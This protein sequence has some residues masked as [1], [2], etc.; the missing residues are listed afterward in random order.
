MKLAVAPLVF[1]NSL[2]NLRCDLARRS[3]F[4][5]NRFAEAGIAMGLRTFDIA[6][7]HPI[8]IRT[9]FL[10]PRNESALDRRQTCL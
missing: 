8:E 3:I 1:T 6:A 7:P 5:I 4:R 10:T 9:S 2:K